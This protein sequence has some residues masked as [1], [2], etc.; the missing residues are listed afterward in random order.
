MPRYSSLI[1]IAAQ[2][3]EQQQR[4]LLE[5]CGHNSDV[6]SVGFSPDEIHIVSGSDDN[7]VQIWD[8]WTGKEFMEPLKGHTIVG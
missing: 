1:R 7:S 5:L 2:D 4:P 8:M 6:Y 3:I